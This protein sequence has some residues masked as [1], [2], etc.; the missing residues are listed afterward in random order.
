MSAETVRSSLIRQPPMASRMTAAIRNLSASVVITCAIE[1]SACHA[2]SEIGSVRL[3]ARIVR[4]SPATGDVFLVA[5][6]FG[7][8]A[9]L[10]KSIFLLEN[11]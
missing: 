10:L 9:L 4:P 5:P 3:S 2:R 6:T 8:A 11:S 7:T 1:P